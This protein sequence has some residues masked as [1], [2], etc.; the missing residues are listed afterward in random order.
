MDSITNKSRWDHEKKNISIVELLGTYCKW[1][2]RTLEKK[3]MNWRSFKIRPERWTNGIN[4]IARND[5]QEIAVD[6]L[7]WKKIGESG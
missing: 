1:D 7:K 5:W 2:R 6:C 4:K 3:I